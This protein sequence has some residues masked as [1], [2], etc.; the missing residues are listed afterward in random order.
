MPNMISS[1]ITVTTSP[2]LLVAAT[3]NATRTIYL[4]PIGNDV[5]IGGSAVTTTTGLVTKKD[6]I[7]VMAIPPQNALYAVTAT[8][9][10]TIRVLQ[11]EGD[12]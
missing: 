1:T 9:T 6:Q 10:V 7:S 2:T 11:P 12:F 8:G 4:E 5:H 3:A